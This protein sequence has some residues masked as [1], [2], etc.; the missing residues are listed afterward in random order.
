[1]ARRLPPARAFLLLR[2][3]LPCAAGGQSGPDRATLDLASRSYEIDLDHSSIAFVSH[4]LGLVRVRGRFTDYQG[5]IVYDSAHPESSTVTAVI[6]AASISTDMPFGDTHLKT[7]DFD[8][9]TF[10][11]IEFKSRRVELAPAPSR[12]AS[13]HSA[14]TRRAAS[15]GKCF[16]TCG[17]ARGGTDGGQLPGRWGWI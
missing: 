13:I 4:I 5:T 12:P 11:T 14:S 7:A 1:M 8:V 17:P 3:I 6:N 16:A 9:K 15:L 10:P 2:G